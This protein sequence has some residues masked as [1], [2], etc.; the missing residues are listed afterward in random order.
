VEEALLCGSSGFRVGGARGSGS[1]SVRSS[2]ALR[3][4]GN[5]NLPH[6][7]REGRLW[8]VCRAW[9]GESSTRPCRRCD[10][11]ELTSYSAVNLPRAPVELAQM[12]GCR[13]SWDARTCHF[14]RCPMTVG[15]HGLLA[16]G[17]SPWTSPTGFPK[18]PTL[19]MTDCCHAILHL[20]GNADLSNLSQRPPRCVISK[21]SSLAHHACIRCSNKKRKHALPRTRTV[22]DEATASLRLCV[23]MSDP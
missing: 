6:G 8:K 21:D 14:A 2:H 5:D 9:R 10:C 13:Q 1:D 11:G 15:V 3:L 16:R 22:R 18:G 19:L 20:P 4:T 12:E 7:A 17:R 23:R